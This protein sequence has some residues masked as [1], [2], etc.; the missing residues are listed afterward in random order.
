M[1]SD[2]VKAIRDGICA[3]EEQPYEPPI[4]RP[5]CI[6]RSVFLNGRPTGLKN[7]NPDCM[8]HGRQRV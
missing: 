5:V 1:M 8:V 3:V 4:P 2:V 6:C 7:L